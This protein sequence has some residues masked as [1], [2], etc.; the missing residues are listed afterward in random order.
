MLQIMALMACVWEEQL[1]EAD[2]TLL[3]LA[4]FRVLAMT[5]TSGYVKCVQEAV[6][7]SEALH[8]ARG[9]L[10]GW[11]DRNHPHDMTRDQVMDNLCGSVA[12]CCV[13]T[14]VL[15][16]GDRHFENIMITRQG[17]IFHIDFGFVL[18][19]DP[20]PCAPPVRLPQQIAQALVV[21]ERLSQC[22]ALAGK[23]YCV[24]RPFAGLW[25]SILQ[26]TAASGGAGCTK[27]ARSP[28]AAISGVRERLCVD[29]TD[30]TRAAAEFLGLM[31][32]SSEGLASILMDKVHAAG[33]YWR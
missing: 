4:S 8:E 9:D 24:L 7:L 21:T 31:R 2:A 19:D 27:L 30:E 12:A 17:E 29:Q 25:C 28:S 15:G 23:A 18:G 32:E 20:K 5:P 14:Y 6:P 3:N 13:V 26:F 16:I 10:I 33:L 1:C 11:L 22:F